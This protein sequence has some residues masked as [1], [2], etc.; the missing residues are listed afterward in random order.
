MSEST[1]SS[2]PHSALQPLLTA[3]QVANTLSIHPH[4]VLRALAGQINIPLPPGFKLGGRW[5]FR[6][7][8]VCKFVDELSGRVQLSN[9]ERTDKLEPVT[10][11]Q[12]PG[13]PRKIARGMTGAA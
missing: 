5:R 11:I 12:Q 8:D 3:E 1:L 10:G 6:Q 7:D 2:E 9:K 4:T 13:R